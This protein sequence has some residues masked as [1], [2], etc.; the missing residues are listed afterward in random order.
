MTIKIN[1]RKIEVT[2]GLKSYIEKKISKLD[3]YFG[4]TAVA[5]V[6]ISVQ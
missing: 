3:R 1:G 2:E 4:E 6:T 5:N